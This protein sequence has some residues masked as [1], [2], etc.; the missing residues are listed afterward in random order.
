MRKI[1]EFN[2]LNV[3]NCYHNSQE[4]TFFAYFYNLIFKLYATR[5]ITKLSYVKSNPYCT[6]QYLIHG[7]EKS[8]CGILSLH[9][10]LSYA[11]PNILAITC[12]G[13]R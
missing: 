9:T 2:F 10:T 3:L 6:V 11:S 7:T 4:A 1:K 5:Y 8:K 12:P 13:L